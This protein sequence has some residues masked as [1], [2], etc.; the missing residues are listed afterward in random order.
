MKTALDILLQ[1]GEGQF[2]EYKSCFDRSELR[3]AKK[4]SLKLIAKDVAVCLAEFA[5]ADGGT[6]LLGV[7]NKGEVTGF[8][9]TRE[10][11]ISLIR[12]AADSWRRAVPYQCETTEHPKGAIV[13]FEV[14]PQVDVF[15][16][17]DGRTPYRNKD[18]TVWFSEDDVRALKRS[19]A[20]TLVERTI[21]PHATLDD[22]DDALLQRFRTAVGTDSSI[23]MNELLRQYDL[24]VANGDSIKLTLAA[25]L[26]FGKPPLTRF[27]ERCDINFRKFQGTEA[28]SGTRSNEIGDK[29]VEQPLPILIE[30]IFKYL[31]GQIKISTRL[32]NLFFEER[33]EYPTFAWQEAVVNA[34]AH[35]SYTF[36]SIGIEILMFDDRLEI[37]SPGYPPEP[38]TIKD[39]Q[40]R[41]EIHAS[42][43][44]R[45]MR[46]LKAL[47]FVRERGEGIP[48]MFDEMEGSCL[49]I[50]EFHAAGE[51]F[52]VTLRNMVVFDDETM[53][54]LKSFPLDKMN[55]RQRRILAFAYQSGKGY[56]SLGDYVKE[57]KLEKELAK[58]EIKKLID[59]DVVEMI[60]SRK[61][62]KYF[63]RTQHGTIEE[64]LR[65]YFSRHSFIKNAEFR[66]L[67]GNI[68]RITAVRQLRGFE[69]RG[70]LRKEG[71]G[72]GTRYY[73]GYRLTEQA[74]DT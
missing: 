10:E 22:L 44:P 40:Q 6:L 74:K 62:A 21:I 34:I 72:K 3:A 31:K 23:S 42:R 20:N 18:A 69:E 45:I 60:G 51:I 25:C 17:T 38:V 67:A 56:F 14:D 19:R 58:Q 2:I 43:N 12:M 29:T 13:V 59:L 73:P 39:L 9:Y 52:T 55:N 4:R 71:K 37:R 70:L 8:P 26:I 61:G 36:R 49:P 48:R 66:K 28:R 16:L 1:S 63:S 54:W 41:K 32:R 53:T 46:V 7:E 24:A 64:K 35:R 50:P 27:H 15:T 11:L 65:E 57:N 30:E 5:N 47:R 68:S 33:P